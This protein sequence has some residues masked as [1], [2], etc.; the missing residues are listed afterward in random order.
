MSKIPSYG[1]AFIV[2]LLTGIVLFGVCIAG[3]A[4]GSKEAIVIWSIPYATIPLLIY[5][6]VSKEE[7]WQNFMLHVPFG[8][9]IDIIYTLF[10]FF[11]VLIA[12]KY[13]SGYNENLLF[14]A[15]LSFIIGIYL[16]CSLLYIYVLPDPF[17]KSYT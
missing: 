10:A 8:Y 16:L 17:K 13:F 7:R 3:D 9:V 4:L 2:S 11:V 1:T 5:F 12:E 6:Y 15:T 14:L